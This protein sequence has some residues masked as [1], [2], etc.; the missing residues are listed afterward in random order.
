MSIEAMKQA[1]EAL[2]A[3]AELIDGEWGLCRTLAEMDEQNGLPEIVRAPI[4]ALR[5]AIKQAEN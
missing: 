2:E 3:C 4:F 5:V 1:L